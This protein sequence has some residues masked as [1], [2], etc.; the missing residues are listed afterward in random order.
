[1][2]SDAESIAGDTPGIVDLGDD[3]TGPQR[4]FIFEGILWDAY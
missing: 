4:G 2:I 3:E 1:V